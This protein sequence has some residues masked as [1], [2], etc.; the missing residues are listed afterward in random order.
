LKFK[1]KCFGY[2][3]ILNLNWKPNIIFFYSIVPNKETSYSIRKLIREMSGF[4]TVKAMNSLTSSKD[5]ELVVQ[6]K[7]ENRNMTKPNLLGIS[8]CVPNRQDVWFIQVKFKKI[9]YFGNLFK[10]Q[11]IQDFSFF[12][13]MV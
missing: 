9:S 12:Q 10:V 8:L 13:C 7:L 2:K 4:Y 1:K 5:I 6:C 3:I 11:F